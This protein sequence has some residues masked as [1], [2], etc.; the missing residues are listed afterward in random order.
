MLSVIRPSI[1]YGSEVWE[2]N[3]AQVNALES[4]ILGGAKKILGC[5]SKT[6]NEAVRGDMGLET[7]RSRR[8][9]AKL[10]WWYKLATM[11]EDRYPRQLFRQKWN[12]KARRGRQRKTWG[13][14]VD[15]LFA[16]LDINKDEWIEDIERGETSLASFSTCVEDCIRER[17]CRKFEEGL[18]NKVKLTMYKSFG[19]CVEFKKYLHGVSDAGSRLLFKFRSG[20]HGLNEELGRHRD[21]EGKCECSL[22][23]AECESVVHVL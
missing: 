12:I 15:D 6:S 18:N 2:G 13:R 5:S 16:S 7:L 23:G 21:R 19:K 8:D 11:P 4:I 17:E 10:K 3:Q 1:E 14:V 9:K 20:T 22:C